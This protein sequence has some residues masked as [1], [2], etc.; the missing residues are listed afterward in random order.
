LEFCLNQNLIENKDWQPRVASA[1][2]F[3]PN[4]SAFVPRKCAVKVTRYKTAE[5]DPE[6]D[7]LAEQFTI[8]GPMYKAIQETVDAIKKVMNS[9][10]VWTSDGLKALEYPPEAIWKQ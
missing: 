10:E 7:H 1:L 2:L 8:E 9:V 5:D 6:R 3:S 4:P